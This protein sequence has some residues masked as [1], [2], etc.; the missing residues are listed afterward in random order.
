MR[1][2][3][4]PRPLVA[5]VLLLLLG[6]LGWWSVAAIDPPHPKSADAPAAEFSAG[7]AMTSIDRIGSQ[8]HVAGSAGATEV[9]QY[10]LDTLSGLGVQAS[11]QDAVGADDALGGFAMAHVRNVVA[12][13]PGSASTGRL[14]LMAHYD[15]VQVSYGANDDGAGVATLL[16]TARALK[17]GPQLRNDVVLVFT[18]AEEACLCGAEAFLDQDPLAKDGGVVLNLESRG[19]AGPAIMFETTRDNADLV[20]MY[21][22]SVPYPVATSFAVEVYRI[23]PN[24]TDFSPFRESGRFTG[25][26]TAYIDGSATYHTPEDRPDHFTPGSLQQLGSNT[27]AVTRAIGAADIAVLSKPSADDA[28]YFPV[29]GTL[30]RY[31]GNLVWV[32]AAVAALVVGF[33]GWLLVRRRVAGTGE[34]AAGFGLALIPLFAAPLVAQLI[35]LLLEWIRPG[36]GTMDD[37]WRPGWYRAA[38]VAAVAVVV[39]TWFA[40]LRRRFGWQVLF[41]GAAA[42][43]AVLGLV[44][45]AITPGGSYL[46]AIPALVCGLVLVLPKLVAGFVGAGIGVLVLAPTVQLFFPALGLATGGAAAFFAVLLALMTLPLLDDLVPTGRLRASIPGIA[47]LVLVLVL[48]GI[49]LAVDR[50]SAFHPAPVQLM[51]AQ[52][53]DTGAAYWVRPG[54]DPTGWSD[55]MVSRQQDLSTEFPLLPTDTTVGPAAVAG[56]KPAVVT[57]D[58]NVPAA[59]GSRTVRLTVHPQRTVR[60]LYLQV[61]AGTVLSASAAGREVPVRGQFSLLFHAPPDGG[62]IVELHLAGTAPATLRVF[63][64]SDGLSALPGFVPRPDWVGVLGSHTS[65]LAV[66]AQSTTI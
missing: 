33:A 60:L 52:D 49:G 30:I 25:L 28:T 41:F 3:T 6:A 2:M 10:I 61:T 18:E 65:E 66:V 37:P 43:F 64:G 54:D 51:Y 12:V 19:S 15:S 44:L 32:V 40:L 56:L 5:G 34:L 47:C 48:G 46:A 55:A 63:D 17:A 59:D 45:A 62:L 31:P 24:D 4:I 26:N 53:D 21:G 20:E 16:E 29:L 50:F 27:L 23:L 35:W 58:S 9:R 36:Y 57:V 14:I 13:I 1:I 7:R 42:W 11:V 22:S 38:V 39:V 8:V